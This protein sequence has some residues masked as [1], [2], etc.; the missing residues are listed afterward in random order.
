M[1]RTLGHAL[2]IIGAALIVIAVLL[3]TFLVPRL[4][5]I[6]LDTVSDTIT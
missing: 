6:P 2:I 3:P 5:V 1:K 4:R